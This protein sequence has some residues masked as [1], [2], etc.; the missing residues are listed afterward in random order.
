MDR[1]DKKGQRTLYRYGK[2]MTWKDAGEGFCIGLMHAWQKVTQA[3]RKRKNEF[4]PEAK[5]KGQGR[6]LSICQERKENGAHERTGKKLVYLSG[7]EGKRRPW[8]DREETCLFVRK[9]RE[10]QPWKDMEEICLFIRKGRETA[11]MKGQGRNLFICQERKGNGAHK[12]TGNHGKT[13]QHKDRKTTNRKG[14]VTQCYI[15][16]QYIWQ[17]T[18]VTGASVFSNLLIQLLSQDKINN[19]A[20]NRWGQEEL[21]CLNL[22]SLF[23]P[24]LR[25]PERGGG[26][27]AVLTGTVSQELWIAI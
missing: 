17:K 2:G 21:N 16:G 12:R 1:A 10:K 22:S 13:G 4:K 6:N 26:S 5:E 11:P 14:P 19:S 23:L 9:G 8:K 7:K 27:R 20:A 15:W 18:L 24:A 25:W 3:H